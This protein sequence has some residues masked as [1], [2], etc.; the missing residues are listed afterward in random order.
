MLFRSFYTHPGVDFF[1]VARALIQNVMTVGENRRPVGGST[2]TQQVAKNFLLGNEVSLN[3]KA[4]EAILAFRI[5]HALSKD[6][7]L[8]L[9]LN[10]IYLGQGSYGV[11]AASLNYFNKPLDELTVAEAAYLGGLPKAPSSY[12]PIRQAAAAKA[13]RK[14]TRLNSSHTDISRMPSS[15]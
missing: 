5:E 2:I 7:I 1:G 4:K 12:H 10:E 15:A 8:E 3:R 6:R 13:D 11:A 14:S 9:Y